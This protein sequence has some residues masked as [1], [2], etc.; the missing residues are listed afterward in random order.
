MSDI[1]IRIKYNDMNNSIITYKLHSEDTLIVLIDF[2]TDY[3]K[4]NINKIPEN[5]TV[6]VQCGIH[7]FGDWPM[8]KIKDLFNNN[9]IVN[10]KIVIK[11]F[12]Q[13]IL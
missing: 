10:Y 11:N 8:Q 7:Y 4:N 2:I 13:N 3:H 6:L 5:Y 12:I 1:N 9:D